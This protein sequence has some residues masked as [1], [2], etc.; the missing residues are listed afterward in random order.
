MIQSFLFITLLSM[1]K[2]FFSLRLNNVNTKIGFASSK[3]SICLEPINQSSD[4]ELELR[5]P[6]KLNLFL[7]ITGRRENGYHDL[8]DFS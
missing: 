2:I 4:W 3:T 5:S 8:G 6:C 1:F 7:R